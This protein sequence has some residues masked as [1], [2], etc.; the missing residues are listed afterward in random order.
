MTS[1]VCVAS[2]VRIVMMKRLVDAQDFTWAMSHVF[3]WSCCE[4]FVGIVCACLPTYAPLV[5]RWHGDTARTY[6]L[7][8]PGGR[9]HSPKL[10]NSSK[11]RRLHDDTMELTVDISAGDRAETPVRPNHIELESQSNMVAKKDISWTVNQI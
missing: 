5:K 7:A 10:A 1:S 9:Y 4:P 3:I 6:G 8:K 11:H 2:A